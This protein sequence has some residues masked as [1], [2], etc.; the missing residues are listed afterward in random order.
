MPV[1]MFQPQFHQAVERGQKRQ[2]IRPPRKRPV[3]VGDTLSLRTWSGAP[4]RSPQRELLRATCTAV[5]RITID[6]D[7]ADDAEAMRDGFADAAEMRSWFARV[8]GIPFSGDRIA[9]E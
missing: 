8:H 6:A 9:W 5:D 7:F 1:L 3:K 2:T 4:Y